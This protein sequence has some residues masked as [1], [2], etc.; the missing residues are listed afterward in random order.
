MH[1][2]IL[3]LPIIGVV[4][5][6]LFPLEIAIPLYLVIL[7]LSGLLYWVIVRA[8]QK[9][10]KTGAEGLIGTEA[11]VM[12]ILQPGDAAQYVVE[13]EG[14]LWSANSP[15]TLKPGNRVKITKVAGLILDVQ[16]A[17]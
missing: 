5:F 8:M 3:V 2:L 11:R 7:L 1:H 14:E 9:H 15:N 6:W 12:A 10:A 16:L 13:V 17:G 4:V